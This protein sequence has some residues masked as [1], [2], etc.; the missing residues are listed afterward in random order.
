M[1]L[2]RSKLLDLKSRT[3]TVN[4]RKL[5]I[6]LLLYLVISLVFLRGPWAQLREVLNPDYLFSFNT[7]PVGVLLLCLIFLFVKRGQVN[8]NARFEF[9]A[10]SSAALSYTANMALGATVVAA[11]ILMPSSEQFVIFR[12]VLGALGAFIAVFGP[13][14]KLPAFLT[15][16]YGFAIAF[17][18]LIERFA[19][20][21]YAQ[22][23]LT[24]LTALIRALHYPIQFQGPVISFT[25]NGGESISLVVS[26]ACAGPFT[27]SVFVA[28]F[29]LMMLDRPLPAKTAPWIFLLGIAGTWL[30]NL[31]R[32]LI[33]L[34]LG[35]YVS[36]QALWTAHYWTVYVLF[37]AWYLL[38]A[39]L[40][41]RHS[42]SV[43]S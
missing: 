36:S 23:V 24:P 26:V 5:G 22:L 31:I 38:F 19:A 8:L 13:G 39:Y 33:L 11:T 18:F 29:A 37:P 14:A 21:G 4:A 17:P 25:G 20:E 41:F 32:V 42:R 30:Q 40:Y 1:S 9:G 10:R 28:I 7:S 15:A 12:L 3:S 2:S 43:S 6:W 27:M 34:A 35:Y 16:I